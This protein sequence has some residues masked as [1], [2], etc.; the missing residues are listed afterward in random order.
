[1]TGLE[2]LTTVNLRC[3]L[4]SVKKAYIEYRNTSTREP[5]TKRSRG[6][7]R[8]IPLPLRLQQ[9]R[10][11]PLLFMACFQAIGVTVGLVAESPL[12]GISL[13]SPG[14]EIV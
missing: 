7:L 10:H 8:C 13:L 12:S 2:T 1:V 9:S 6:G 4:G 3:D 11:V 14:H 5:I